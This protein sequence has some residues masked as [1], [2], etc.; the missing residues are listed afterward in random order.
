MVIM[1]VSSVEII[2]LSEVTMRL[3]ELFA[4]LLTDEGLSLLPFKFTI[5]SAEFGDDI[6]SLAE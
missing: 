2:R 4:M 3:G 1:S 6:L 5:T